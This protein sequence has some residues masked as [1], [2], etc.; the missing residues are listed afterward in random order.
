LRYA[1]FYFNGKKYTHDRV[2]AFAL[3][4]LLT[5][6]NPVVE[7]MPEEDFSDITMW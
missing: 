7:G 6:S 3:H 2:R 4:R 5:E 1:A